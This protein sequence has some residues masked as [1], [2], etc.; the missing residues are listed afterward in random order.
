MLMLIKVSCIQCIEIF[1]VNV[2]EGV[3]HP[4]C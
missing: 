3:I 2:N 1:D 4:V